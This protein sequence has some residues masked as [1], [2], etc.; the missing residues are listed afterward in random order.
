MRQVLIKKQSLYM[1]VVKTSRKKA[2]VELAP[3]ALRHFEISTYAER[4]KLIDVTH[5]RHR[6]ANV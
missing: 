2:P 5:I 3:S 6:T 1:E 4:F